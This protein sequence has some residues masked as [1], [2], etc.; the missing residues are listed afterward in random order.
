MK[1]TKLPPKTLPRSPGIFKEWIDGIKNNTQ[2]SA[3]FEYAAM[4][5]DMVIIGNMA[6]R[7]NGQV[8]L[9]DGDNK[10]FTNNSDANNY[11]H[12]DYREGWVL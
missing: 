11:L 2:P 12:Q 1:S 8:L 7:F 5:T 3:N 4:L 6:K 10:K 9:W